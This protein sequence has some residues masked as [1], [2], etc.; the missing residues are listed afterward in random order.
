MATNTH[1]I[2]YEFLFEFEFEFN[3]NIL[4]TK[5]EA[6]ALAEWRG[7]GELRESIEQRQS[8]AMLMQCCQKF[9]AKKRQIRKIK[10]LQK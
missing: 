8:G 4:M 7:S 5:L 3:V 9:A 10:E 1:A 6:N 2:D